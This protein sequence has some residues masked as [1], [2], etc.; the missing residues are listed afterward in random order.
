MQL[1]FDI[2]GGTNNNAD[3]TMSSMECSMFDME[4][5]N[6]KGEAL[7]LTSPM[8]EVCDMPVDNR[9]IYIHRKL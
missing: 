1:L 4:A 6:A 8:K 7:V 2:E 3:Q 5:S 9:Q